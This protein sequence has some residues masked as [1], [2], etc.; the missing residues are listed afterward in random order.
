MEPVA[1]EVT[2]EVALET[3]PEKEQTQPTVTETP[4]KKAGSNIQAWWPYA[5]I[6][7][8]ASCIVVGVIVGLILSQGGANGPAASDSQYEFCG[9][10]HVFLR[11][12]GQ[13]I[14]QWDIRNTNPNEVAAFEELLHTSKPDVVFSDLE[15]AILGQYGGT[16][17][18][19]VDADN[20]H[21][22]GPWV[23]DL[24]MEYGVNLL[25]TSNNHAYNLGNEGILSALEELQARHLTYAG[26]GLNVNEASHVAQLTTKHGATIGLASVVSAPT[27]YTY[28]GIST[29]T[30]MGV[31]AMQLDADRHPLTD[32]YNRQIDAISRADSE[33]DILISYHHNHYFEPV[34]GSATATDEMVISNWIRDYAQAVIDHGA[35]V[36]VAHGS[37]KLH[38]VEF[39]KGK[40]VLWGLGSTW[41]Q[42]KKKDGSYLS[43][44][45]ESVVADICMEESTGETKA[46]RFIPVVMNDQGVG[47]VNSLDWKATRGIP[48]LA[49]NQRG[50]DILNRLKSLS[51]V[52]IVVDEHKYEAYVK[53][54]IEPVTSPHLQAERTPQETNDLD[55]ERYE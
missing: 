13:A 50:I 48:S 19:G 37:T 21:D 31:N 27:L 36:Y 52:A 39:Y 5:V 51:G 49:Q 40:P 8:V 28:G 43:D 46:M 26:T 24:L 53:F 18:R 55:G 12:L 35:D 29:A 30:Q 20:F 10:G 3:T 44:S 14:I 47:T 22:A 7:F 6:A 2:L 11:L 1:L 54:P 16:S 33:N 23:L 9:S 25:A 45:W 42:T 38:G 34:P 17:T 41:F 4:V 15:L 32:Q